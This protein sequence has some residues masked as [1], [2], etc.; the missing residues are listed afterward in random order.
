MMETT[1]AELKRDIIK[2]DYL[3]IKIIGM[4]THCF[5]CNILP[6]YQLTNA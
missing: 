5:Y 2:N 1:S 3:N 4:S 6:F